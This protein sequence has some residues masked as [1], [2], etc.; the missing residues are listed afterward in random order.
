MPASSQSPTSRT[1]LRGQRARDARLGK[2]SHYRP[3]IYQ[4]NQ[5]SLAGKLFAYKI[6]HA[7]GWPI[8]IPAIPEQGSPGSIGQ[9]DMLPL[10]LSHRARSLWTY[11]YTPPSGSST[12]YSFVIVNIYIAIPFSCYPL[13]IISILGSLAIASFIKRHVSVDLSIPS[14]RTSH[15]LLILLKLVTCSSVDIKLILF[16]HARY[17]PEPPRCFTTL[18]TFVYKKV[19]YQ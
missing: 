1:T 2:Q 10:S 9:S 17:A 15:L 7:T 19:A 18:M 13:R 3:S 16:L 6:C 12:P 11:G 5:R 14:S 4:T 8:K